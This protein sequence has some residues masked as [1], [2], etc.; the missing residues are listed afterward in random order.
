M[1]LDS[2]HHVLDRMR[3]TCLDGFR[4]FPMTAPDSLRVE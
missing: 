4:M 3:R 2:V 1:L